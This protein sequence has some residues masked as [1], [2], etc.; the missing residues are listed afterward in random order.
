MNGL[1]EY[2]QNFAAQIGDGVVPTLPEDIQVGD[3]EVDSDHTDH[4]FAWENMPTDGFWDMDIAN[5]VPDDTHNF[6]GE[7]MPTDG[8]WDM[9]IANIVPDDTQLWDS[10]LEEAIIV[11]ESEHGDTDDHVIPVLEVE[12]FPTAGED[13]HFL[14]FG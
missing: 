4:N 5:I 11:L 12:A 7:N 1:Q 8:F 6:A 9:D 10:E 13:T 2:N 3:I 14:H